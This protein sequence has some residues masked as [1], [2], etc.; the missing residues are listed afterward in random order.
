MARD[1]GGRGHG[2]RRDWL[3][4]IGGWSAVVAG[5]PLM[6]RAASHGSAPKAADAPL[7]LFSQED[8]GL[9]HELEKANFRYFWEQT[10]PQTGL[11]RDRA[12]VRG[13]ED[14]VV[15]SIAATGFGLTALAIGAQRGFLSEPDAYARVLATLRFLWRRSAA[16][17]GSCAESGTCAKAGTRAE[18]GPC[19]GTCWSAR[20]ESA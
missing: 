17:A 8:E 10:N 7:G 5:A 4:E 6:A 20:R 11:V 18:T 19:A 15:A 1:S 14:R 3:K 2:S 12:R 13:A 9:L 16:G